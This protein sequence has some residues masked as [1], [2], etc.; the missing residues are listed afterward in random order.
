MLDVVLCP[1]LHN[2]LRAVE[3][4]LVLNFVI[5]LARSYSVGVVGEFEESGNVGVVTNRTNAYKLSALPFESVAG[6]QRTVPCVMEHKGNRPLCYV[7]LN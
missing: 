7:L 5:S 6:T 1:S 4:I 2:Y 3:V